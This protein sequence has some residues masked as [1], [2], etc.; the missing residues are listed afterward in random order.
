LNA[1]ALAIFLGLAAS[2]KENS[3][4]GFLLLDD[5]SQSLGTEHKNQLARLLDK[6]AQHKRLIVATMDAEFH[7]CLREGFTK[8]KKEYHFGN[9]TSEEGPSVTAVEAASGD[10][11]F[12]GRTANG[13]RER[14][15]R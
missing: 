2:S 6:V 10:G 3:T 4:F 15:R 8:A 12:S 9:W 11:L 13:R 1:L 5:P 7:E 14:A